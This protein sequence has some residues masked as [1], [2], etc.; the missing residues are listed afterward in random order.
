MGKRSRLVAVRRK[1]KE[2]VKRFFRKQSETGRLERDVFRSAALFA[3]GQARKG[4]TL[5]YSVALLSVISHITEAE[6][7]RWIVLGEA[8]LRSSDKPGV[9]EGKV[10]A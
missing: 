7:E 9:G 6:A 2:R 4:H 3:R 5:A 1:R 8:M 10:R